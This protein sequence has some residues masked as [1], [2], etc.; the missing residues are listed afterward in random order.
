MISPSRRAL[1]VALPSSFRSPPLTAL[2][3]LA[4]HLPHTHFA[5]GMLMSCRDESRPLSLGQAPHVLSLASSRIT[6]PHALIFLNLS[7]HRLQHG[8]A[9]ADGHATPQIPATD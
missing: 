2:A 3:S 1:R 7:H 4:Y 5:A 8:A 6:L 9:P